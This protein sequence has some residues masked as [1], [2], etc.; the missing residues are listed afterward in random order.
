MKN[1]HPVQD[2]FAE[3][4]A[5]KY[6]NPI[7]SREFILN[8][9]EKQGEPVSYENLATHLALKPEYESDALKRRLRAMERDGQLIVNRRGAYAL[10]KKI[11]LIAGRVQGHKDGY[12]FVMGEMI[13]I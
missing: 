12:G 13:Y 10:V 9:L 5:A 7:P 11:D 2:P 4:E 8:Y 6:E 1:K 3:R